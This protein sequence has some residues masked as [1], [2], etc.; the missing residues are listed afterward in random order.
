MQELEF[1]R[2]NCKKAESNQTELQQHVLN[3]RQELAKEVRNNVLGSALIA[4][5]SMHLI[6]ALLLLSG[7]QDGNARQA[8]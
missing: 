1:W 6:S 2:T 4:A 8:E 3:L 5:D 7:C